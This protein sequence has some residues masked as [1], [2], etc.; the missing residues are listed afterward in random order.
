MECLCSMQIVADFMDEKCKVLNSVDGY[1]TT[2]VREVIGVGILS[3]QINVF[4]PIC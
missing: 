2:N 3:F 1:A 4:G